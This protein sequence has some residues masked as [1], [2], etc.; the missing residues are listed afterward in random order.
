VLGPGP[1]QVQIRAER[2]GIGDGR[3][4]EIRFTSEN[5]PGETCIGSVQVSVPLSKHST[6]VDSGQLYDS[7]GT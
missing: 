1:G 4:Y 3:V 7:F 2:S 5:G 6:A